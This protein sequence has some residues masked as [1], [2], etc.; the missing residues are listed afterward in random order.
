[1]AK[2]EFGVNAPLAVKLWSKD[3]ANEAMRRTFFG[4]FMS[5]GEDSVFQK[6]RTEKGAGDQ[7]TSGLV[8]QL[9]GDG[10]LGDA[11]LEGNE[12]ALQFADD[13]V[14]IDQ[15]RHAS[16]TKGRMTEQRVPYDLRRKSR[17]ALADWWARKFDVIAANH[18]TGYTPANAD[19]GNTGANTILAPSPSRIIRPNG[20]TTDQSLVAGDEFTLNLL[21]LAKIQAEK[22][23]LDA[24]TGTAMPIR[25]ISVDGEDMY[26][27]FLHD[28]Q[29]HNLRN[30]TWWTEIQLAAMQGGDVRD[31]P[32]FSGAL[33]V[34]NGIVLHK[35]SRLPNGVHSTTG[36]PV[37]NTRR[38]VLVGA[39]AMTVAF[40]SSNSATRYTW[41][42]EMFDY[43]NQFGV[44]AGAIFGMKKNRFIPSDRS[45]TGED[46][47]TVV[48]S[49]YAADP[50]PA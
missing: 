33:G 50:V 8:M 2:T 28:Y 25:P 32:I 40:G 9:V 45:S 23:R 46:F 38:A 1:M 24:G 42:E 22:S 31:N 48:I 29:V 43:G 21:D 5:E 47:G 30:S 26:V 49:T 37:P 35:W 41:N 44:S 15:L 6:D 17:D 7:I 12:E 18:L 3:L 39:Q 4:K 34:Y 11:T 10:I 36:A 13:A 20:K 14:R 19:P 16:R 27:A